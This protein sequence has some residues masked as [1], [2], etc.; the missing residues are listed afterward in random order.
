MTNKEVSRSG[1]RRKLWIALPLVL[2]VVAWLAPW[3]VALT[4][5][6]NSIV[7]SILSDVDGPITSQSA[8]FGWFSPIVLN[9][10]T[11]RDAEGGDVFSSPQVA[12]E[13][14]LLSL[15]LNHD[16]IGKWT[17]ERPLI[18]AVVRSDGSNVEQVFHEWI[19]GERTDT[20]RDLGLDLQI[21][22]GTVQIL[23]ATDAQIPDEIFISN[24]SLSRPVM[25]TDPLTL[26]VAATADP[27]KESELTANLTM[28]YERVEG[29]PM[30]TIGQSKL[31]SR[32]LPLKSL[33]RV[34]Q[35]VA[36]GTQVAGM[37]TGAVT[38][39][40]DDAKNE[41]TLIGNMDSTNVSLAGPWLGKDRFQ[42]AAISTKAD[43]QWNDVEVHINACEVRGELGEAVAKGRLPLGLAAWNEVADEDFTVRGNIDLV[44]LAQLLPDTLRIRQGT[45]ITEGKVKW[46][47]TSYEGPKGRTWKA[48]L[49]ATDLAAETTDREIRWPEPINVKVAA[50]QSDNGPIIETI[51]CRSKFLTIE[52]AGSLDKLRLT[53]NGDLGQLATDV[54]RFVHLG[55][56]R[57]AGVFDATLD[58]IAKDERIGIDG[59][60]NISNLRIASA[61]QVL[62]KSESA[63]GEVK[64]AGTWSDGAIQGIDSARVD[65]KSNREHAVAQLLEPVD[66]LRNLAGARYRVGYG[67]PYGVWTTR[68]AAWLGQPPTLPIA[69]NDAVTLDAKVQ[70]TGDVLAA[71]EA[72][73]RIN[74]TASSSASPDSRTILAITGAGTWAESEG[75]VELRDL[76]AQGDGFT[77]KAPSFAYAIADT[78]DAN[79]PLA[80]DATITGDLAK[81][82]P[83]LIPPSSEP[84]TRLAGQLDGTLRVEQSDGISKANIDARIDNFAAVSPTGNKWQENRLAV[85]GN[86]DWKP[87][88]DEFT[89]HKANIQG[90]DVTADIR[91]RA[92]LAENDRTVDLN[93]ELRYDLA[94][95]TILLQSYLGKDFSMQGRDALSFAVRGRIPDADSANDTNAW[96]QLQGTA[97]FG[98][99][100]ASYQGFEIGKVAVDA[101][102]ANGQI[103]FGRI[104]TSVNDGT[105]T[106]VPLVDLRGKQPTLV[107]AKGNVIR[108]VR[109]TPDTCRSALK[110]VL[111]YLADA[112]QA[113]GRLSL[114]LDKCALPLTDMGKGS[115]VGRVTMHQA[116]VS[117]SSPLL[118]E[119]SFLMQS[120]TLVS[121]PRESV[122]PFELA[123]GRVYH[124][125][126]TLVVGRDVNIST[127]G[128]VGVDGTLNLLVEAPIPR[129]IL[130]DRPLGASLSRQKVQVAVTG[131]LSKPE[132]DREEVRRAVARLA[133]GTL[134]DFL[135]KE[136]GNALDRLFKRRRQ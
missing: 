103:D 32:D 129:G 38:L 119:L 11:I 92:T 43:M 71:S 115:M 28:H 110:Y 58:S 96:Q 47:A 55:K 112:T 12:S 89:I 68:L 60:A 53:A 101:K 126:V 27:A 4:P 87:S 73:L 26:E 117:A 13:R 121:M 95:L 2:L 37:L 134:N 23:N 69:E 56:L 10:V 22:D 14:T 16:H 46:F 50:H 8:S 51:S 84:T 75:K 131:T 15:I 123:K 29:G 54:G 104:E 19:Y 105:L 63:R 90:R 70:Q 18:R 91:G 59:I 52:G 20:G 7:Q 17:I 107:L 124:D 1:S 78:A 34:I 100:R 48:D 102:L 24:L 66:G 132:V 79:T 45:E 6:R 125:T 77:L 25:R 85:A 109:I 40:W 111:P 106:L 44:R 135:D 76:V 120:A 127:R 65:V 33:A 114:D 5:A 31:S 118:R 74:S 21:V 3:F 99:D 136:L 81:L 49:T 133:S 80:I 128:S 39:A 93:G 97:R 57:L 64:I 62:W 88:T 94:K 113:E 122:V 130:G 35:R 61:E 67:G 82:T 42:S 83:W 41:R 72:V 116:D 86:V 9:D 36:P 108:N 30:V 98:W